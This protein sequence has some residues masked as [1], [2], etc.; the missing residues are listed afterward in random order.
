MNG[1]TIIN[2]A[3][4]VGTYKHVECKMTDDPF[5]TISPSSFFL[6]KGQ[7]ESKTT[8]EGAATLGSINSKNSTSAYNIWANYFM[9]GFGGKKGDVTLE[10]IEQYLK[11]V[12]ETWKLPQLVKIYQDAYDYMTA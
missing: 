10:T 12:N 11:M 5:Y 6:S 3:I 4:E 1:L 7:V 2:K 9:Y 8:L